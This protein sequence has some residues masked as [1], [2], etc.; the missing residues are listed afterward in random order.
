[1]NT[2]DTAPVLGFGEL[3][4]SVGLGVLVVAQLGHPPETTERVGVNVSACSE[5]FLTHQLAV[6]SVV[7]RGHRWRTNSGLPDDS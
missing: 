3:R 2:V 7:S 5:E 1:M 4:H 6:L